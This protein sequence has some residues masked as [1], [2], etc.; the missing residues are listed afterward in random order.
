[1][2]GIVMLNGLINHYSF[3]RIVVGDREFRSDIIIYPDGTIED[4]WWRKSGHIL[5]FDDIKKLIESLPQIIIAGTG[6]P[7]LL[8]PD[9]DLERELSL[10]GVEFIAVPSKEAAALYNKLITGGKKAGACFHLSC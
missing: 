6:S 9:K 7:G 1:M 3:G 8:K 2:K 5:C 10:K 4:S